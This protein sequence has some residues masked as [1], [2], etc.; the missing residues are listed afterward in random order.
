MTLASM[1]ELFADD[2][3]WC[4]A[5]V[6]AL[7]D[8]ETEHYEVNKE[9]Q[10]S[11]QVRTHLHDVQITAI[12]RG[13]GAWYIP[14]VGTEVMIAFDEGE[15]EGDAYIMNLYGDTPSG[16]VPGK[17]FI[18]ADEIQIRSADGTAVKLP[19]W[20]DFNALQDKVNAFILK[21]N[22]HTHV[23]P[24]VGTTAVTPAVETVVAPP[25]GTTKVKV[26]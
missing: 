18:L 9:G 26:E 7:H 6:V 19:T 11:V 23:A 15:F 21:Y 4:L 20:A 8:G 25:T 17:F 16:L 13:G 24:V 5:A 22:T 14:D 1:K 10:M 2:H 3:V 12:L